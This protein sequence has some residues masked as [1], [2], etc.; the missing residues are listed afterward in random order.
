MPDARYATPAGDVPGYLA[1]PAGDGPWPAVVVVHEA[2]GLNDDIRRHADR[3]AG[4]GYLALAPDLF[5]HGRKLL[6]LRAAFADLLRGSGRTFE[7]IDAARAFLAGRSD[8]TGRVGVIGFCMGGG[9]ALLAAPRYDFAAASANYGMVPKDVDA[10]LA[11]ACPIVGSYGGKDRVLRGAADRLDAALTRLGVEHDVKEYPGAGHSFL[12]QH[13]GIGFTVLEKV[14]GAG[15]HG[16]SA[17]DA[18]ERIRAF[19]ATHLGSPAAG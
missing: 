3:L 4:D 13:S 2:F 1:V 12:N 9:F 15:Y 6:C 14:V 18:Q 17:A 11:G 10:V 7:Q 19:F 8:C 16:P 5:S